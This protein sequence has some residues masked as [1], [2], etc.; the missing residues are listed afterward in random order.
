MNGESARKT[1]QTLIDESR[2]DFADFSPEE[3]EIFAV[4]TRYV[5]LDSIEPEY[6]A[7]LVELTKQV[8]VDAGRYLADCF[9]EPDSIFSFDLAERFRLVFPNDIERVVLK[10]DLYR[11]IG[12]NAKYHREELQKELKDILNDDP[13]TECITAM[14]HGPGIFDG[15]FA[16]NS[17]DIGRKTGGSKTMPR[18]RN[19]KRHPPAARI[20]RALDAKAKQITVWDREASH[21]L[22]KT[23]RR[24]FPVESDW[25]TLAPDISDLVEW[26][27]MKN[28]QSYYPGEGSYISMENKVLLYEM[29]PRLFIHAFRYPAVLAR[30]RENYRAA[31]NTFLAA[32]DDL[33]IQLRTAFSFWDDDI[34]EFTGELYLLL[35]TVKNPAG[36]WTRAT[37]KKVLDF[38]KDNTA[39]GFCSCWGFT[40]EELEKV[41][42]FYRAVCKAS[43]EQ[44]LLEKNLLKEIQE[45]REYEEDDEEEEEEEDVEWFD[46]EADEEEEEEEDVDWFDEEADE[47]DENA[48]RETDYLGP[49]IRVY[50]LAGIQNA[51]KT[52][53]ALLPVMKEYFDGLDSDAKNAFADD[54]TKQR[55][56]Y[57]KAA[58]AL[59]TVPLPETT[60]KTAALLLLCM[61]VDTFHTGDVSAEEAAEHIRYR[62]LRDALASKKP[63]VPKTKEIAKCLEDIAEYLSIIV[64]DASIDQSRPTAQ[65]TD[66]LFTRVKEYYGTW[67]YAARTT[68]EEMIETV[69]RSFIDRHTPVYIEETRQI[70]T[71]ICRMLCK[72]HNILP[73]LEC[74]YT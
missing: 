35:M 55:A 50:D 32:G 53:E 19:E 20:I 8:A 4:L 64:P 60:A 23:A 43:G 25:E 3:K 1:L 6:F 13:E 54:E 44:P 70:V 59:T 5:I 10:N 47:E 15:D 22:F 74:R 38:I 63:A 39:L 56:F 26:T 49:L 69:V 24:F 7:M 11:W 34:K 58:A 29:Q 51:R 62:I 40:S 30:Y 67:T 65:Y 45:T 66:V 48:F 42:A 9:P 36:P 12:T 41:L 61:C 2:K 17:P 52:K 68:L 46:E 31:H 14:L 73:V 71:R 33:E 18:A 16:D 27:C 72:A 28:H 37:H 57:K 21:A